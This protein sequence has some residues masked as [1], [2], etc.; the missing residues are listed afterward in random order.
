MSWQ[1]SDRKSR[2]PDN[3]AQ[4]RAR[5]FARDRGRCQWLEDGRMC[6]A[7]ATDC[8]HIEA[9]DNH[10][11]TNLRALCAAHHAVKSSSEGGRA[12]WFALQER[13]KA[14]KRPPLEHPASPPPVERPK[15]RGF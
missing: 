3:W 14:A 11:L 8:D 9:G 6:G 12:S 5:V 7:R 2:L 1:S 13:K 10:D 15:Y 4:L